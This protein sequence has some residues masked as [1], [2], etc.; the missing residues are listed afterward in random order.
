MSHSG[1]SPRACLLL[2]SLSP[3]RSISLIVTCSG[4][5]S[6]REWRGDVAKIS[7]PIS[8]VV[9]AGQVGEGWK[10]VKRNPL[11]CVGVF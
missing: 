11:L 6:L 2:T 3:P 9:T 1:R 5:R 7:E 8:L 4:K 10:L